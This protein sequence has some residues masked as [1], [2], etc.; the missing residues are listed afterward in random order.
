M[1][2][3][4]CSKF[5]DKRKQINLQWLQNQSQNIGYH[6]NTVRHE[7][8]RTFRNK[9]REYRKE[10]INEL[11]QTVR[12]KTLHTPTHTHTHTHTYIYIYMGMMIYSQI[13]TIF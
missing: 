12:T 10:R 3:K 8:S 13:L 5:L 1:V 7:I 9:K 2:D 11:E 6:L 4:E